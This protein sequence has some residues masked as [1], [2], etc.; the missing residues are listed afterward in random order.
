MSNLYQEAPN[1]V[2]IVLTD[3]NGEAERYIVG[4]TLDDAIS[5]VEAAFGGQPVKAPK[6]AR[7]KRR[8]KAE[9][10]EM[11]E[12]ENTDESTSGNKK[13]WQK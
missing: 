3:D 12:K 13:S 4:Q 5:I 9:M 7:K 1:Q 10:A 2:K 6:K 8:T 11:A